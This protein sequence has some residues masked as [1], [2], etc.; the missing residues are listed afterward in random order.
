[1]ELGLIRRL[2]FGIKERAEYV[3]DGAFIWHGAPEAPQPVLYVHSHCRSTTQ[4]PC[5]SE[6]RV[7][8]PP[9]FIT[10]MRTLC[11]TGRS[12]GSPCGLWFY[13]LDLG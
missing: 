5:P 13:D 2:F 4:H 6:D 7:S 9:D 3:A 11:A 8:D 12:L 1:M 10:I